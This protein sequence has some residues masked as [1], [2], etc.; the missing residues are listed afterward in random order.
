MLLAID[1]GG[2]KTLVAGFNSDGS[3]REPI[4]FET[5]KDNHKYLDTLVNTIKTNYDLSEIE[6][7]VI[8]L[9]GIIDEGVALHCPNLDWHNFDIKNKLSAIF[10]PTKILVENDA[11]LAGLAEIRSLD[12]IPA[13]GLYITIS[14]GIGTGIISY[15]KINQSLSKSEGGHMILE[16]DGIFRQWEDFASGRAIKLR[17]SK[18]AKDIHSNR[19]WYQITKDISSGLLAIIPV[20]QPDIIIIGGSIGTY[21]NRYSDTLN[22]YLNEKLP[23]IIN[24]PIIKQAVHPEQAVL[25]GCYYHAVD[26]ID[27]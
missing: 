27:S 14:T 2:T 19:A 8:A 9:P 1:T 25:Y 11:N 5:P 24:R 4:R 18:Y 16:H 20:L 10:K 12:K 15:G 26:S 7:I 13:N 6:A 17:Y 22:D 21:F 3:M 23:K